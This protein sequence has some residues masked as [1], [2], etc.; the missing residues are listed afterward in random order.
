MTMN[1]ARKSTLLAL[2]AV[3]SLSASLSAI[4]QQA[5][6]VKLPGQGQRLDLTVGEVIIKTSSKETQGSISQVILFEKPGYST[7]LQTNS[8]TDISFLVMEGVLTM[9]V[10]DQV[11]TYP[12]NSFV[13]IPKGTPHAHA[14]LTNKPVRLFMTFTP[15]GY[16]QFFIERANT[17][18]TS[19]PGTPAYAQAM[20]ALT[21]KYGIANIDLAP[22]KNL[23]RNTVPAA[24]VKK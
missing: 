18:K 13:Y 14:N 9:R 23:Q 16:E 17:T 20:Q 1:H 5:P 15:G 7:T 3:F 21:T 24:P 8:R 4:A 11:V 2:A 22:F 6:I 12:A 19:K 10:R